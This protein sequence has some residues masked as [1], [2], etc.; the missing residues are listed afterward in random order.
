MARVNVA[1]KLERTSC[2][3][4]ALEEYLHALPT[5]ELERGRA[6]NEYE[7]LLGRAA[8]IARAQSD[9][10]AAK[11]TAR[12]VATVRML[13]AS[14]AKLGQALLELS[15]VRRATGYPRHVWQADLEAAYETLASPQAGSSCA[16]TRGVRKDVLDFASSVGCELAAGEET[17][18]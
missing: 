2:V 15:K 4:L 6:S 13:G 9:R 17:S 1:R 12:W 8:W 5:Y 16:R 11:L 7:S 10:R 3:D 18:T 14:P